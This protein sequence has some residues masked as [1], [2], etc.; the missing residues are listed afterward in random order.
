[1]LRLQLKV[2]PSSLPS[3]SHLRPAD[4]EP[5]TALIPPAA[6]ETILHAVIVA[7]VFPPAAAASTATISPSTSSA[8]SPTAPQAGDVA[9]SSTARR[10]LFTL[11]SLLAID[12]RLIVRSEARVA[13]ELFDVLRRGTAEAEAVRAKEEVERVRKKNEEGWGGSM[14][15]WVAT[16]AGIVVRSPPC[17]QPAAH[18]TAVVCSPLPDNLFRVPAHARSEASLSA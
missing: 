1:M 16:G 2:D 9:Y 7:S 11:A 4:I 18:Q 15:R 3:G 8:S 13:A 5:M 6:H 14:G 17:I 10:R 12:P